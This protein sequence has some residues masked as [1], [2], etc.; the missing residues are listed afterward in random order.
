MNDSKISVRYAKA[1]FESAKEENIL[2]QVRK[3]MEDVRS[4]ATLPDFLYLL[5]SPIIK[6]SQK[7]AAIDAMFKEG[8]HPKSLALLNMVVKNGRELYIPAIARNYIDQYKKFTGVRTATFSSASSVDEKVKK[9]IEVIIKKALNTSV[10]LKT[11]IN[12]DLIGGFIIR[13]DDLQ[14][15]A[16][17]ASNLKKIKKQ[18]L[19]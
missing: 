9:E 6:E 18:L 17:V 13:V 2:D 15:D 16:S 4:I 8:F 10:E 14:Y 1:L 19:N 12:K 5:L 3:D 11:T 7:C